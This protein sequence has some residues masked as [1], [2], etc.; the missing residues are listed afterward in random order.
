[1]KSKFKNPKNINKGAPS[2]FVISLVFH[3][4]VFFI[5]GL[6]VVFTALPKA[7]PEFNAPPQAE[8]PKMKLKKP[9]VKIKKSAQPKPS[10]RIVAK[11][12]TAKM[13][14]IQ[15][16]DLV[17]TGEGLLGGLGMGGEFM[18]IPEIGDSVFGGT[19]SIGNDLIGTFYDFKRRNTGNM[20][21]YGDPDIDMPPIL[22]KFLDSGWDKSVLNKYYRSPRKLYSPTVVIAECPSMIGPM[23]FGE[24]T[25]G[26]HWGV[27]YEGTLESYKDIRFRF[28]GMG[29][30]FLFVGVDGETVLGYWL[31]AQSDSYATSVLSEYTTRTE[32]GTAMTYAY[33]FNG[34]WIDLKAGEQKK[35]Q[36]L[37]AES[38]G[39][40]SS[41]MLCVEVD[42]VEY[43]LNP[44]LGGK[45]LPIF[46]TAVLSQTQVEELE[47]VIYPGDATVN[48]GPIFQDF[49]RGVTNTVVR[50][51]E[52][53][54]EAEPVKREPADKMRVWTSLDGKSVKAELFSMMS[55]KA[56]LKTEDGRELK[57]PFEQLCDNDRLYLE[58]NDPPKLKMRFSYTTDQAPLP[59]SRGNWQDNVTIMDYFFGAEVQLENNRNYSHPLEVEYFAIGSELEGDHYVLL[60]R[61]SK[62]FTPSKNNN[63]SFEFHGNPV[64]RIEAAV[65]YS[66]RIRGEK[67][68]GYLVTV[69]DER[70]EIIQYIESNKF[71]VEHLDKLKQLPVG[72]HF[73]K[74]CNRVPP[75]RPIDSDRQWAINTVFN[76]AE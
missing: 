68:K 49:P 36:V 8:R 72:R 41:F 53:G 30:N 13:P 55:D 45:T 69:T 33:G 44:Y 67:Y 51:S 73:D 60:Q 38:G 11:V 43:P 48:Q 9:K 47:R 20:M 42:G 17:G 52:S 29:D 15:I 76:R 66:A 50:N 1:M 71:L 7:A 23:A 26:Y 5:A 18:D 74:Y 64:R 31:D 25:P 3:A 4:A 21:S 54:T 62:T 12:K 70:G 16:P 28:Y 40:M 19:M 61:N 27:L 6:F 34:K 32:F 10:S 35:L 56:W 37:I 75:P 58:M 39:G 22:E 63:Y 14:E 57:I 2:G 24:D 65:H 59:E 46:Q